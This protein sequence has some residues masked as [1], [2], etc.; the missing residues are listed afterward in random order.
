MHDAGTGL[1]GLLVI[2]VDA[3]TDEHR[4]TGKV[5]VVGSRRGA[6]R[7]QRQPVAGVRPDRCHHDLSPRGHRVQCRRL[8]SVGGDQRPRLRRLPQRLPDRQQLVLGPTRQCDACV[9]ARLGQVVRGQFPGETGRAVQDD[10]ELTLRRSSMR[11]YP[12]VS[13]SSM[14]SPSTCRP[15]NAMT[16]WYQILACCGLSTQWFSDGK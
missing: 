9:A 15:R 5:G 11:R 16:T 12:S 10:V 14:S 1:D 7:N 4:L 6:R 3:L 2:Q 8:R 13:G